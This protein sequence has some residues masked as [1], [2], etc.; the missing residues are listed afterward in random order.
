MS[1]LLVTKT[2]CQRLQVTVTRVY[3]YFTPRK[4]EAEPDIRLSFKSTK[5]IQI[6]LLCA[7]VSLCT[8]F[9][10]T[11]TSSFNNIKHTNARAHTHYLVRREAMHLGNG[12][13]CQW[14]AFHAT[15]DITIHRTLW[16]LKNTT[17]STIADVFTEQTEAKKKDKLSYFEWAVRDRWRPTDPTV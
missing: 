13:G 16:L 17:N 15:K 1:F 7:D 2:S 5:T 11:L 3:T 12:D 8:V 14:R 4:R 9:N 6:W 10:F